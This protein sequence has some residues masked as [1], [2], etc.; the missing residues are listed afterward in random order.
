MRFADRYPLIVTDRKNDCRDFWV[1]KLGFRVGFDSAWFVWLH[2]EDQSAT[3]AFLSP[4]HP[5]APPGPETFS[6]AGVTLE[7]EVADV[8]AVFAELTARGVRVGYPLTDE[9]FGQRRF[10]FADPAGLWVSI[11]QM[12]APAD[13]Y[14]DPYM[15]P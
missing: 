9:P 12:I 11:H 6:G 15:A 5:S 14:W 7:I 4:D 8:D 1:D 13:G 3:I 10:G 2:A